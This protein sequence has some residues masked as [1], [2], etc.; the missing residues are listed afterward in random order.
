MAKSYGQNNEPR[1]GFGG[2][3]QGTEERRADF[4]MQL[5]ADQAEDGSECSFAAGCDNTT[6]LGTETFS[7]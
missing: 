2:G 1:I 4:K 6:K 5:P 3:D 7:R